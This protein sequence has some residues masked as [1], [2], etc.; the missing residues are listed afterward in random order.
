MLLCTAWPVFK[1][2]FFYYYDFSFCYL[3][4]V[5]CSRQATMLCVP[6]AG[7]GHARTQYACGLH[8]QTDGEPISW[9]AATAVKAQ[10]NVEKKPPTNPPT[11]PRC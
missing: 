10:R 2:I 5:T 8:Q 9:T 7:E 3:P 1:E 11:Q 4:Q 6:R